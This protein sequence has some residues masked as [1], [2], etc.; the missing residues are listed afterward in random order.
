VWI[1]RDNLLI[2]THGRQPYR[3][4]RLGL[5]AEVSSQLLSPHPELR[6]PKENEQNTQRHKKA[7]SQNPTGRLSIRRLA[8]L[9]TQHFGQT[10]CAK[11]KEHDH[12]N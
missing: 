10:L 4:R 11:Q 5:V 8:G 7:L 1:S 9:E 3:K 6:N 12:Q 2:I